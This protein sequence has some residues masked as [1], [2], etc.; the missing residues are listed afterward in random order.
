MNIVLPVTKTRDS[1]VCLLSPSC[2]SVLYFATMPNK[3][4]V[5]VTLGVYAENEPRIERNRPSTE[6][7][8]EELDVY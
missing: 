7:L 4:R 3:W 5:S 2:S 1:R 8:T 6:V